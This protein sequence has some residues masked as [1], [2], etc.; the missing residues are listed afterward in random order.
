[1]ALSHVVDPLAWDPDLNVVIVCIVELAEGDVVLV[2]TVPHAQWQLYWCS[3]REVVRQRAPHHGPGSHHD[4]L[5]DA[6]NEASAD[7]QLKNKNRVGR[8]ETETDVEL[9]KKDG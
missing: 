6:V 5:T 8:T 9:K 1:V 7:L 4:S 2:G 3:H